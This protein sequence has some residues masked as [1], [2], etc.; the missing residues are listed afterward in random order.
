MSAHRGEFNSKL[1]FILATAGSAVGLGNIWGFP[2]QVGSGGGAIFVLIYLAFCFILCYPI[3]V[4]EV[5]IGRKTSRNPVGA[6]NA[7]GFRK[8]SFIGKL[9]IVS[10]FLILSFYNVL[11]AWSLGYFIEMLQGNFEV[12]QKF[13]QFTSNVPLIAVYSV[14]FMSATAFIVSGGI[15]S[16]I[17]RTA[18]L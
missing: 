7:L 4:T 13:T 15:K 14:I 16:G 9:G 3:M 17:E 12:G 8:W 6:F 5:A 11:A 10:G 1:G 2:F 18:K